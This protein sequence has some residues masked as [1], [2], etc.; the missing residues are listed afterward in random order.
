[1]GLGTGLEGTLVAMDEVGR[2]LGPGVL[3]GIGTRHT[4]VCRG[5]MVVGAGMGCGGGGLLHLHLPFCINI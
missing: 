2:G 1:M 3:V 5:C 4:L